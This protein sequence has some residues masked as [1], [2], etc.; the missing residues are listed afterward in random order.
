M[1]N[2][3]KKYYSEIFKAYESECFSKMWGNHISEYG[4]YYIDI[5]KHEL[6]ERR[7]DFAE[8]MHLFN[9]YNIKYNKNAIA[10]YLIHLF[11]SLGNCDNPK[12]AYDVADS[13]ILDM[14][15]KVGF[16]GIQ[17]PEDN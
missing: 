12:S 16:N 7:E 5:Y 1:E 8:Y 4:E 14:N 10:I 15:N 13:I 2:K 3:W 11:E 6:E 9:K 17:Y